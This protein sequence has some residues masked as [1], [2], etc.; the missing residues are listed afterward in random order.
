[1]ICHRLKATYAL[2]FAAMLLSLCGCLNLGEGT[3]EIT[4]H[5][6]LQPI[7]AEKVGSAMGKE[8]E[9]AVGV[10]P[11]DLPEYLSRPQM[12]T[13][14]SGN[15]YYRS[16]FARWASPLQENFSRILAENLSSELRTDRVALFPWH[17][18]MKVDYRVTVEV[19]RFDG[20]PGGSVHLEA[21]WS[22][23]DVA[24]KKLLTMKRSEF[25]RETEGD[26]YG[27]MAEAMSETLAAL[28]CEISATIEYLGPI[29]RTGRSGAIKK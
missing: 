17:G 16:E 3:M 15:E 21:R 8:A 19:I 28:S 27:A 13:R 22:I 10:G 9:I 14:V 20:K 11:I 5:Y 26:G 25:S 2:P 1:M 18:T 29:E 23:I 24:G 7:A 6:A 4:R 12:V